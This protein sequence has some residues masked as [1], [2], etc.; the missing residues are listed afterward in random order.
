[1]VFLI[2]Q[3]LSHANLLPPSAEIHDDSEM[4]LDPLAENDFS[5]SVMI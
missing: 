3:H 2:F 1:M 4:D 5:N